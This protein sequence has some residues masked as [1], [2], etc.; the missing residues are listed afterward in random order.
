MLQWDFYEDERN[1]L[2]DASLFLR[3]D[4]SISWFGVYG[5]VVLESF[6]T[7]GHCLQCKQTVKES[8]SSKG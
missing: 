4:F 7:C 8:R 6:L 1:S 2:Q 5:R 3:A